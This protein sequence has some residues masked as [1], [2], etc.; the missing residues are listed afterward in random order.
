MVNEEKRKFL[1]FLLAA[2]AVVVAYI[3]FG[4]AKEIPKSSFN[5]KGSSVRVEGDT[6]VVG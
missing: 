1:R 3:V 2:L 4:N 6:L 5:L